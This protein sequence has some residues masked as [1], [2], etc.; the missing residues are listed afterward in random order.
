[1]PP[2]KGGKNYK[3]GKK[4]GGDPSQIK[5]IE[6]DGDDGQMVGRV[7]KSVGD[8]RFTVYCN[9]NKERL[10]RLCG[11]MR[12]GEWVE[13][14]SLVL[15]A[16]RELNGKPKAVMPVAAA[17]NTDPEENDTFTPEE[18]KDD[19]LG[20]ILQLIDQ[21][22]YGKLKKVPGIN[23]A[24]FND[25]ENQDM[26]HV[27]KRVADGIQGDDDFFDRSG[28][29]K[30]DDEATEATDATEATEAIGAPKKEFNAEG[31]RERQKDA[32]VKRGA[33]REKKEFIRLDDL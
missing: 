18:I 1:M 8:R 15:I 3:K 13:V 14:G 16:K 23:L 9:D 10:C 20:D 12:K 25:I 7:L 21:S 24:L 29:E 19:K 11:S 5:M 28:D 26:K 6:I 22:L 33:D 4:G 2:N 31:L 27:Q 30:P 32:A 17:A